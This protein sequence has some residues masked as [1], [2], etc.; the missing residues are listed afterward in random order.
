MKNNRFCHLHN[1]TEYSQLDGV[2]SAK[3]YVKIAQKLEFEYLACTDHGNI[4]GLI[5]FQD[6]C[7]EN[8]IKPVL[9]CEAYIV[10]DAKVKAREKRGHIILLIKNQKGFRNLCKM[11]N[12]ANSD[13]FYYKPRIDYETLFNHCEGLVIS[14]ACILSFLNLPDGEE[15][16]EILDNTI[17]DDLYI[18]VQPHTKKNQKLFNKYCIELQEKFKNKIIA[19]NDCHYTLKRDVTAQDTLLAIN[20]KKKWDDAKTWRFDY[21]E[22]Y[23]KTADEMIDTFKLQGALTKSQYLKALNNTTEIAEKCYNFRIKKKKIKLP[24]IP[25]VKGKNENEFLDNLCLKGYRKIFGKKIEEN[26]TY[27][28]RYRKEFKILVKND[29]VKYFLIVWELVNWCKKQDIMTGPGRGSVGGSLI[30]Y[31]LGI[32]TVDPI[33]YDLLFERFIAKGRG[34]YPDIDLD[35]EDIRRGEIKLH[36]MDIYGENNIAG[37]STFIKLKGKYCIRDVSRVFDIPI[38]EVNDLCNVI[39]T[40][41]KTAFDETEEGRRYKKRYKKAARLALTL[42]NQVRSVGTHAAALI[43]SPIS[44]LKGTRGCLAKRGDELLVNWDKEEAEYM[45]LMKLD[46][47][48]LNT[49]TVLNETK[50]LIK[51]KHEIEI[52]YTKIKP[53]D[54]KIFKMLDSLNT[55][56]IFQLTGWMAKTVTK[57]L[58]ISSFNDIVAIMALGRPGP[59]NSGMTEEYIKRKHGAKWEKKNK[60]YE[61]VLKDTYG[62]TIY[63]EDVM[64]VINKVAGLPFS[65]AD[66]IR[67]I[68][69]K[70]RDVKEFKPYKKKFIQG[71]LKQKTLNKKEAINIWNGFL[72]WALYGFNKSH[73]VEYAMLAYWCAWAKYNYPIEFVCANLTY[74]KD[75]KK[76]EILDEAINMG[77]SIMLPKIGISH[78]SKWVI[79]GDCLVAPFTEIKGIG[80]KS[81]IK[82]QNLKNPNIR[83]VSKGFFKNKSA[84]EIEVKL[85]KIQ[86]IAIEINAFDPKADP[87]ADIQKYFSFNVS[88]SPDVIYP[89]LSNIVKNIT[90]ENI[91]R[92]TTGKLGYPALIKANRKLLELENLSAKIKGCKECELRNE[93]KRPVAPNNGK[94]N[95]AVIGE[96][97]GRDE[98]KEGEGFVGKSGR[99]IWTFLNKKGFNRKKFHVSNTVKCYPKI[100]R[101]PTKVHI[102]TCKHWL[103]TELKLINCKIILAM[104]NTAINFF[105][106][107][108]GGIIKRNGTTEWNEEYKCWICWCVHPSFVLRNRSNKPKFNEGMNNF[109]KTIKLFGVK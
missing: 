54:K 70:K 81:A 44:L 108:S 82:M 67:K 98:D 105:T 35:F 21:R 101:T 79:D 13:G 64:F 11:L 39:E 52:D 37:I 24:S 95:I 40:D 84:K 56:G 19:T 6:A 2:G 91:E 62:L 65:T 90:P 10:P 50:R 94:Y 3:D 88:T 20:T 87:T 57:E 29:F 43:V 8:D 53:N 4:D 55:A 104:G 100:T 83:K 51:K 93:C 28:N 49:L 5:K 85:T 58:R 7:D 9:G 103:E 46:I 106:G 73:S 38:K 48:G 1:H 68:I 60:V 69:G 66:K 18:E 61:E 109:I 74:G 77:M 42:E 75:S 34:D 72:K 45:G 86:K 96:A 31:L 107:D 25:E 102:K 63:Q 47:L 59:Y 14:T 30:A 92:I 12:Y 23:L 89:N 17:G 41:I 26:K 76:K 32:T 33:E 97:P 22:L 80:E 36:L 15:V 99:M 78:I 71:C 27:Y 16:F